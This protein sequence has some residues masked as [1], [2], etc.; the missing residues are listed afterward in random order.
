ME[1]DA[2]VFALKIWRY[3]LYGVPCKIYIGHQRL[4][5]IFTQKE[6]NLRQ[7]RWFE[8]LKD[9]G[10]Q[11]QYHPRK[12]NVVVD[13]MINTQPDI[14]RDLETM[15]V[16]LEL[17]GPMDGLLTVLEVQPSIIEE[18]KA[19]QKDDAKLEKLKCNVTQGKSP[20]FVRRWNL[21]I[22]EQTVRAQ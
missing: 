16:E 14:L 13:T 4:K 6:I 7:R 12:A 21:E 20:G 8:L 11:I 19:S 10:L 18:I 3:Y 1:L 15:G 22:S 5:Y 2:I 17:P 9:Y